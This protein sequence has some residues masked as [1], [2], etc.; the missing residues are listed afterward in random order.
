MQNGI[1]FKYAMTV[2]LLHIIKSTSDNP[3]CKRF[4]ILTFFMLFEFLS[5]HVILSIK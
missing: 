2:F 1:T 3:A 4:G 5:L